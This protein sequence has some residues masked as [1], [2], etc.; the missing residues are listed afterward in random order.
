MN[1]DYHNNCLEIHKLFNKSHTQ[2]VENVCSHLQVDQSAE[3]IIEKFLSSSFS[4]IKIR[5][6]ENMPKKAKS[7]YLYFCTDTREEIKEDT[8]GLEKKMGDMSKELAK[9]WKEL[10][11]KLKDAYMTM[12]EKD[13]ERFTIEYNDYKLKST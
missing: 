2:L 3:A 5:K 4:K 1:N 11:E 6:D 12:A 10:D 8:P 9:R 13:K 7:A